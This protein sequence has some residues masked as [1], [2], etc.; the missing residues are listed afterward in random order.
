M[1]SAEAMAFGRA[2][3]RIAVRLLQML[4]SIEIAGFAP[5]SFRGLH[6]YAYLANL[7]GALWDV[8]PLD[9]KILKAGV[10]YYPELRV[11][12]DRMAVL[13]WVDLVDYHAVE[14]NGSWVGEGSV[15]LNTASA[16]PLIHRLQIFESE[17]RV[18]EFL[19][20]L[21]LSVAPYAEELV[22]LVSRD[23]TWTDRRVGKGDVLDYA[24]DKDANYTANAAEFFDEVLPPGLKPSRGER[25]QYYMELLERRAFAGD[26]GLRVA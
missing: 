15:G 13:G 17:R 5:I 3:D 20:R 1:H 19:K 26:G 6:S 2:P 9:G 24:E 14:I 25:L 22:T 10:P 23:V 4:D 8:D 11:A 16:R 7:L 21:A 12:L 18:S